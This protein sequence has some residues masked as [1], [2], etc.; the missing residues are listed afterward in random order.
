MKKRWFL[1][2]TILSAIAALAVAGAGSLLG[3]PEFQYALK[4]T[5]PWLLPL[6][7]VALRLVTKTPVGK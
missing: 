3:D 6:V 7:M 4:E 5:V 2:K 1:S